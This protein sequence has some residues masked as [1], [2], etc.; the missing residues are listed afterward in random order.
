M[1][2]IDIFTHIWPKTFHELLLKQ[3]GQMKDMHRRSEAVP[4]MTN[5]DRR[6]AVMDMFD[7]YQ[8]ILSLASPPPDA[9]GTREAWRELS[10]AGSDGMAELCQKYPQ[11]F[12]SFIASVAMRDPEGA[13]EEATRA[14]KHLGACGIQIYSNVAGKALD[15]PEFR[16]VFKAMV[17]L[18]KPIWIHPARAANFP[19]YLTEQVSQYEIW[20]TFGWPYESSA[21]QARIVFSKMLD[22]MPEL[23]IIIH[24]AG[25]MVPFFEGR[26][27]AGWDQLG[28][29]TSSV[30][31]KPL[32]KELK[33]RPLDYF[34]MFY[35]DTATF[36]SRSAL[37][38]ALDFYG[39]DHVLFASDAPFDPEGGPMYIRETIKVI[40][41]LDISKEDREKLY[42]KNACKLLGLK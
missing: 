22:E 19:D 29:R 39:V 1:R 41:S 40:D 6:F 23:K 27:G 18:G 2:K 36:G 25:G 30:D 24:H 7:E 31:Y 35:A 12:P 21:A 15:A 8:Q 37:V 20:W 14:V 28:L 5:L 4:M 17:S 3:T 11:R 16:P 32:L 13:V 42:Y 10:R 34:K 38:C 26:V 33:K 9:V